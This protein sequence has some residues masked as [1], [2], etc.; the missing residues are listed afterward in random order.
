MTLLDARRGRSLCSLPPRGAIGAVAALGALLLACTAGEAPPS[1]GSYTVQFPSTAAAVATDRVQIVVYDVD[2]A[3][4]GTLCQNL[5]AA[6]KRRE[7]TKAAVTNGAVNTCELFYGK[8]PI[9]VP[10]GEKALLAIGVRKDQDFL[11]GCAI[12]TFGDGDAPVVIPLTLVDVANGVPDT[13]CV[14]VDDFCQKR[15]P[16]S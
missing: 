6:R 7:P 15:C 8:K 14:T 11:I 16:A 4:R 12:G 2:P 1:T 5:I 3:K 13:Q 9:T 10:Y